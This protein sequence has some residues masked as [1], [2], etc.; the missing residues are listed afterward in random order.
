MLG[1]AT[2]AR[3]SDPVVLSEL[4]PTAA[5][6]R[7]LRPWKPGQSGNPNGRPKAPRFTERDQHAI[8]TALAGA[9]RKGAQRDSIKAMQRVPAIIS[10][11]SDPKEMV[12]ITGSPHGPLTADATEP[13]WNAYLL[14]VAC[15][16]GVVFERWVTSLDAEPDLLRTAGLN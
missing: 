4:V 9:L 13:V 1:A 6:L 16:C 2:R 14:T 12:S 8:L 11:S 15:S 10:A 5:S 7:N 3:S